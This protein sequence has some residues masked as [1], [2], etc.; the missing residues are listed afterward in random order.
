M[1]GTEYVSSRMGGFPSAPA[2]EASP[3]ERDAW[4]RCISGVGLPDPPIV[5]DFSAQNDNWSKTQPALLQAARA[6]HLPLVV[7]WGPF[8]HPTFTSPIAK[9]PL[10]DVALAYPWLE[11]RR[12][13]AYPVFT[14]ASSDQRS[15]WL[16]QAS[17]FDESGQINAYFRWKNQNDMPSYFEIQLWLAHPVVANPPLSMPVASTADITLRRLQHFRIQSGATYAWQFVRDGNP[18]SS[19]KVTPDAANLLT[20]PRV[21]LTTAP[22]ELSVT[23]VIN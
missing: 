20:I 13:E 4:T 19:G 1:A 16:G 15:P 21:T 18:V 8:H 22:G 3:A 23:P 17:T 14:N 5:V 11:I 12:N 7:S 9:F 2:A 10:C 6:G